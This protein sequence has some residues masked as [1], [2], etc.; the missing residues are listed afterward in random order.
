MSAGAPEQPAEADP[1][2]APAPPSKPG[3]L[4]DPGVTQRV[5]CAVFAW[6]VTVAPAAFSR[7]GGSLAQATAAVCLVAG[8]AGPMLVPS[9]KRVGRQIGITAF[10]ALSTAVWLLTASALDPSRLDTVRAAIGAVAWGVY[11]FSWG[12]PWRFRTDAPQDDAGGLLRARN[13]LP[14][15]A[16]PVAAAGVLFSLA[17]LL[18]AWSVRDPARALLAQAAGVGLAVAIVGTA[19]TVAISRGR[20]R[21]AP[22]V[23]LPRPALRAV[24]LLLVAAVGGAVF[25]MVRG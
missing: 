19:A 23:G 3:L 11:A 20:A 12:E 17:V 25:V 10:L 9:A 6:A 16:V 15:L 7:A 18:T 13:T 1:R 2:G 5:A 8:V 4:G 22:H 21:R 24:V 14:P